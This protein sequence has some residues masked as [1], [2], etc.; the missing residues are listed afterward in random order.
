LLIRPWNVSRS[1]F[2]PSMPLDTTHTPKPQKRIMGRPARTKCMLPSSLSFL[3]DAENLRRASELLLNRPPVPWNMVEFDKCRP[4]R[5][6]AVGR[7]AIYSVSTATNETKN[8]SAK[9]YADDMQRN[10]RTKETTAPRR[11]RPSDAFL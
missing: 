2:F 4:S 10:G 7:L 5:Q 6:L 1:L 3:A 11:M 8:V 9:A